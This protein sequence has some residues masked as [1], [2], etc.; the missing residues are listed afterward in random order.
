VLE[1]GGGDAYLRHVLRLHRDDI[2]RFFPEFEPESVVEG[3]AAFLVLHG[4]ETVGVVLVRDSGGGVAQVELDYVTRRYRDFSPG[5]FVY[6]ESTLFRDRG[7]RTVVA[8]RQMITPYYDRIGFRRD[9]AAYVLDV[10]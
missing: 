10:S 3:R 6:R 8:P 1:V 9:E 4:A 2:T 5:E 7:F